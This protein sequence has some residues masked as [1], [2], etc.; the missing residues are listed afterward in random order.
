MLTHLIHRQRRSFGR[1]LMDI[2]Y[3]TCDLM[4]F[5]ESK[6]IDYCPYTPTSR[7]TTLAHDS[8]TGAQQQPD[9]PVCGVW[10]GKHAE[11]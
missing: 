8:R 3:I 1:I 2:W 5:V 6:K 11:S 9:G 10:L 7:W 4:L